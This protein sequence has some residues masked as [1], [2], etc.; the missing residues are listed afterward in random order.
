[1]EDYNKIWREVYGDIQRYGPVHR[2]MRRLFG[3]LLSQLNYE[4]AIDVGCGSGDNLMLIGYNKN[5]KRLVGTD[6]SEEAIKHASKKVS[7]EYKILDIQKEY[8]SENFDLVFCSFLLEH[9]AD[10]D[11]T[12]TN[13]TNMCSKYLIV[14]TIQGD[15]E[16]YKEWE[17]KMGH[18]RNYR[19]GE[20]EEKLK[21]RGLNILKRIQWGFPFYSPI[22]RKLQVLNPNMGA[23]KY[24]TKTK[25]I[26]SLLNL[27]YHL[28]SFSRGDVLVILAEKDK[29]SRNN[30]KAYESN[31]DL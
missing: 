23:G 26:A 25:L 11:S 6:I 8:I 3:G 21:Q 18:V 30:L 13:L 31:R 4:T 28:N 2:H 7:A 15:Y 10:D 9:V 16:L 17:L 5:L 12:L 20:L 29:E 24:D 19:L 1:M 14:S 22:V 27:F